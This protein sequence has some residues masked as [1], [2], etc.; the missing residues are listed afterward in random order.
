MSQ[1]FLKIIV[2]KQ[3]HTSLNELVEVLRKDP[4]AGKH[5]DLIVTN[6]GVTSTEFNESYF[7][8]PLIELDAGEK[9]IKA[10][11]KSLN[12]S[13]SIQNKMIK[14]AFSNYSGKDLLAIAKIMETRLPVVDGDDYYFQIPINSSLANTSDQLVENLRKNP[15]KGTF[16][17]ELVEFSS[18]GLRA[19][20]DYE[21]LQPLAEMKAKFLVVKVV[22]WATKL[23]M[24]MNAFET[25]RIVSKMS[26]TQLI[27]YASLIERS[28]IAGS[29]S[30]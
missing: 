15:E 29:C 16:N 9:V 8:K 20:L 30:E 27:T 28:L 10:V 7:L 23:W 2:T 18:E 26:S 17:T 6:M 3:A 4:V 22:E 5:T 13:L 24:K 11:Q 14:K 1:R 12:A 19:V 25:K 21:M